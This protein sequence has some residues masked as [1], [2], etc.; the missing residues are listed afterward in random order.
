MDYID[1]VGRNDSGW[2]IREPET[3][4]EIDL[5][6]RTFECAIMVLETLQT[7]GHEK[8]KDAVRYQLAKSGTSIGA[9]YEEAQGASS[10]RDFSNKI[11]IVYREVRESHYWCRILKRMKWG[12]TKKVGQLSGELEELRKIF[13]RM[14]QTLGKAN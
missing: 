8:E 10:R 7:V 14:L 6:D 3:K 11:K 2:V 13:G 12:D 1:I 4:Y 9:N 5:L